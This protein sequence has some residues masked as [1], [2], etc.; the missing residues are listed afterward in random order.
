M[1]QI[2]RE[3]EFNKHCISCK[4]ENYSEQE[5]PCFGC[6]ASA[7]NRYTNKPVLWKEKEVS[8]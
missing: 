7:T 6:L 3:V 2:D 8:K 4:Y 1:H 5:E